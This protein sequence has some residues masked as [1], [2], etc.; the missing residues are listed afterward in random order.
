[1]AALEARAG[2]GAKAMAAFTLEDRLLQEDDPETSLAV[3][4]AVILELMIM[5]QMIRVGI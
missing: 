4:V 5:L 1:M 3:K 2:A